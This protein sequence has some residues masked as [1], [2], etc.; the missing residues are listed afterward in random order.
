MATAKPCL[1][2]LNRLYLSSPRS[3]QSSISFRFLSTTVPRAAKKEKP[4]PPGKGQN[5]QKNK[6][7]GIEAKKK[8]KTSSEYTQYD[9]NK[10]EMFSLCDA[11][12]YVFLAEA[13]SH[14]SNAKVGIFGPSKWDRNQRL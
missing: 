9:M 12:R 4:P 6:K 14:E 11:M 5:P 8:K 1:A 7:K 3:I 2:Q 10:A 13:F